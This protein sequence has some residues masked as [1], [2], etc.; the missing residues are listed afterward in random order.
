VLGGSRIPPRPQIRQ[1]EGT[2]GHPN[3]I[4]ALTEPQRSLSLSSKQ[5]GSQETA[6]AA[7][8]SAQ[9]P[10]AAAALHSSIS[11]AA[12]HCPFPWTGMSPCGV[13]C[14]WGDSVHPVSLLQ[15]CPSRLSL[16]K[17]TYCLLSYTQALK[18][19]HW[20]MPALGSISPLPWAC[21]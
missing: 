3:W 13:R 4:S 16:Q 11:T 15:R 5:R 17:I 6:A 1:T 18:D 2:S 19:L 10:P 8:G 14:L 9:A 20:A 12:S 7:W 21:S